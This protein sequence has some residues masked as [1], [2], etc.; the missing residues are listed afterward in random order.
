MKRYVRLLS[1]ICVSF[2]L[3]GGNALCESMSPSQSPAKSEKAEPLFEGL[4]SIHH[5]VTTKSPLAQKYFDQGLSFIY[6][7]NHDEAERSFEQAAK[8]DP[9]MAIAYWGVALVL[10]PNYNQPGDKDRG[11]RAYA[12]F[13]KAQS[14]EPQA[15]PEETDL[16]EAVAKRYSSDGEPSAAHDREY[17]NAMR[18]VAHRYPDDPDVQT[19]FAESLM[20][21][22]PWQL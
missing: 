1:A 9:G 14:L 4:G 16:I 15:A 11:A 13:Q 7:F 6:A 2:L 17:A 21:L 20:D 8:I 12:A 18:E 19:L 10:G 22:H 3:F 5:Q